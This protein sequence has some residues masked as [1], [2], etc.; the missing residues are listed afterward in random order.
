[1]AI[2]D[3]VQV[4]TDPMTPLSA[5][6]TWQPAHLWPALVGVS[7]GHAKKPSN[8]PSIMVEV[9]GE[10]RRFVELSKNA[11]WFLKAVIRWNKGAQR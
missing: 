2:V 3:K 7:G 1:M 6:H 8:A 10:Q 5:L 4:S 11:D 9:D